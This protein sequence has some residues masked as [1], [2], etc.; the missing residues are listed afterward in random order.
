MAK[1]KYPFRM[2]DDA[3]FMR[4]VAWALLVFTVLGFVPTYFVPLSDGSFATDE[5][6]MH[7]HAIAGFAFAAFFIA[8]PTMV[9]K[10]NWKVHRT[11]GAVVGLAVIAAAITG[12]GVQFEMFPREGELKGKAVSDAF[13]TFQLTPLLVG[14][15]IWGVLMRR[16]PD[17]H[18]RLMYAS[19]IAPFGTVIGR[20]VRMVP[21]IIDPTMVGQMTSLFYTLTAVVLLVYDFVRYRRLHPA[22]LIGLAV[23]I[24]TT[25][26]VLQIGFSD[27]WQG[28]AL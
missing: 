21:E 22:S 28:I 27:W 12:L 16:R 14:F 10:G 2:M 11:M 15:F 25:V 1:E 13:R 24:V 18:W 3:R 17:W 9:L 7:P 20:Y 4:G 23:I 8:Q 6:W 5:F 26:I 19:A